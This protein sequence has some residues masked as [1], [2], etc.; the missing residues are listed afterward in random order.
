MNAVVDLL[1][2]GIVSALYSDESS[3]IR[4][5]S[6]P[7]ANDFPI[8][9]DKNGKVISCYGDHVWDLTC[10]SRKPLVLNFGDG[11]Q[12]KDRPEI[13]G[14]NAFLLR[15]IAAWLLYGPRAVREATTLKAKFKLIR[16]IFVHCSNNGILA[17]DLYRYPKVIESLGASLA[18]SRFDELVFL[19]HSLY[20]QR[21][22]IGFFML[23]KPGITRL[24]ACVSK[25]QERQTPYIPPRIWSHVLTRC[26]EFLDQYLQNKQSIED[27]FDY[28]LNKYADCAGSLESAC[29]GDYNY[30]K[31]PFGPTDVDGSFDSVCERFGIRGILEAWCSGGGEVDGY[32]S[33]GPRVLSNYFCMTGYIGTLYLV[34]HT[35]MRIEEAWRL[36][37]NC[38]EVHVD[39]TFGEVH[40]IHSETSKTLKDPDAVW[41]ASKSCVDAVDVMA[42]VAHLRMKAAAANP[43]VPTT[44]EYLKNPCLVPRP[45]EPWTLRKALESDLSIRQSYQSL[46]AVVN[47]YPKFLDQSQMIIR[48]EDL[49]IARRINPTLDNEKFALGV[50]WALGWHQLRRTGAVNMFSSGLVSAFALQHQMKHRTLLMTHFYCQGFSE[51][52][53][54][55]KTRAEILRAMYDMAAV[56][57]TDLFDDSIVSPHG[58]PRKDHALEP[59]SNKSLTELQKLAK[60]GKIP[61]RQ[62]PF[63][64]CT[65]EGNCEYGGFDNMIR[66]GGGDGDPP[67]AHGLFDTAR[68]P[69]VI[70]LKKQIDIQVIDTPDKSPLKDWLTQMRVALN[71]I[72]LS[73]DRSQQQ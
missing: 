29:A 15:H 34:A 46:N 62:T 27:C 10:W 43:V 64:G 9:I 63:G 61:W 14:E 2:L 56:D 28:T 52:A 48:Q 70:K 53:L 39:P 5:P 26:K 20:E 60:A 65:K 49:D 71:N 22:E 55:E 8:V 19:L 21:D 58:A 36:R 67:C 51:L 31:A 66:C 68:K 72:V 13:S 12:R 40:L 23:D 11:P 37:T 4:P 32:D 6:W 50:P 17:S 73:M 16:P 30:R 42:S 33:F 54:D 45:Y 59:I 41:I 44:D 18:A 3:N 38:H 57:A 69:A 47:M 25:H 35:L 24:S 7:P 1:H